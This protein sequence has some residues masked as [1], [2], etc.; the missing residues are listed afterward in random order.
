MNYYIDLCL[1]GPGTSVYVPSTTS[2]D[3]LLTPEEKQSHISVEIIKKM[4]MSKNTTYN[5]ETPQ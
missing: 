4:I 2:F 3:A 5:K 1:I